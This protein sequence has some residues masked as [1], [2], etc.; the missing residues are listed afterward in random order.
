MK[1]FDIYNIG[2][3]E[4]LSLRELYKEVIRFAKSKSRIVS[5]PSSLALFV[6]RIL[7]K[8]NMS[9]LGV[10]QYTMIGRSLY[11]DTAKIKKKLRWKPKMT[12]LDT[13]T[14]NYKW[15]IKNKNTL[16]EV[17]KHLSSNRSLPKLKAFRLLKFFS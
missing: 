7:E 9:P 6:L 10:Y 5:L 11:M 4:I 1:G 16:T 14:E 2:A 13:F 17:G 12:N 15:Y 8:L 3:D